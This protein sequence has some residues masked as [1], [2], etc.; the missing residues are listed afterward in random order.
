[1]HRGLDGKLGDNR[2]T[3]RAADTGLKTSKLAFVLLSKSVDK[4]HHERK[5]L[6][7]IKSSHRERPKK[8][9]RH[10]DPASSVAQGLT[11]PARYI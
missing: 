10:V 7:V 11:K 6:E 2:I 3:V 5:D 1:M 9:E 4:I 8:P